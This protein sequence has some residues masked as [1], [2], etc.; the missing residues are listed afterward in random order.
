MLPYAEPTR[1]KVDCQCFTRHVILVEVYHHGLRYDVQSALRWIFYQNTII[2]REQ[3][4]TNLVE[5]SLYWP[6]AMK[7]QRSKALEATGDLLSESGSKKGTVVSGNQSAVITGHNRTQKPLRECCHRPTK[8]TVSSS[9]RPATPASNSVLAA[10][11]NSP[12]KTPPGKLIQV[13]L[14][15]I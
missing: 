4:N 13:G 15:G 7:P 5:S 14:N 2:I 9:V 3:E 12:A 1:T 6:A 10:N 8:E 11:R